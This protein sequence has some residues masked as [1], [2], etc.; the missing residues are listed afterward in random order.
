[1]REAKT[2]DRLS[3]EELMGLYQAGNYNAF[4]LLYERFSGRVLAYLQSKVSRQSA[5]ELLQESFA[6]LH[7][8]RDKYNSQ[9]PFLPWLFTISRN[10]LFD[11]F[12]NAEV[13][14]ARASSAAPE[15]LASLGAAEEVSVVGLDFAEMLAG[16]PAGQKQAIELRYMQ[17]WSFE[18][19][20]SEMKTSE[21]N[22]RQLISRGVKKL[23]SRYVNKKGG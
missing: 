21:D 15:L 3:D 2:L 23:R 16:L 12:K 18:K 14:L 4:E 9:F 5:E 7:R 10:V 17:E 13:K 8:S 19:I 22:I 6:K 1:M 20:A 11:Y